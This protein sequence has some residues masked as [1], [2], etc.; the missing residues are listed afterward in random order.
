[1]TDTPEPGIKLHDAARSAVPGVGHVVENEFASIA[2]TLDGVG[3]SVRL[4][5]EDLRTHKVR[6][7]DALELESLVWLPDGHLVQL[8]D[9]SSDRWRD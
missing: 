7:L 9:P 2:V 6:Y 8:L 4:R 1:M 5:V 3:N